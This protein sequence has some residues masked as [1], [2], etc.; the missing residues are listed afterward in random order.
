MEIIDELSPSDAMPG[1]GIGYLSYC[2]R[3]GYQHHHPDGMVLY[4]SP[5][6]ELK[7]IARKR[8]NICKLDKVNQPAAIKELVKRRTKTSI[9][10]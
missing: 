10:R 6:A 2:V 1:A 3:H 4:C 5:A 8:R 9:L 7:R